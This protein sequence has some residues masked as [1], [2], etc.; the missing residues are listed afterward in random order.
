MDICP[1]IDQ[2]LFFS[3]WRF[4]NTEVVELRGSIP[5]LE[6]L[7]FG[8][9]KS[10]RY[11]PSDI[12]IDTD[13]RTTHSLLFALNRGVLLHT[14]D[15]NIMDSMFTHEEYNQIELPALSNFSISNSGRSINPSM[16]IARFVGSMRMPNVKSVIVSLETIHE[17]HLDDWLDTAFFI[18]KE[19][20]SLTQFNLDISWKPYG[21]ETRHP[22]L[23]IDDF[24]RCFGALEILSIKTNG[25][26]VQWSNSL[27]GEMQNLRTLEIRDCKID[28]KGLCTMLIE[29]GA[30]LQEVKIGVPD[31]ADVLALRGLFPHVLVEM[32]TT[33]QRARFW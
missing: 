4:P 22:S 21:N 16:M 18:S 12:L 9:L 15:L 1:W 23:F 3:R 11:D 28:V 30:P 27:K 14:I 20:R 25:L 17:F 33:E 32:I 7:N 6:G 19:M 31:Y 24:A 26:D 13:I 8:T 5:S 2:R 10:L 29:G